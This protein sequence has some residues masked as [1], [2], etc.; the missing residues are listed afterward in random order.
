MI[1]FEKT[2]S[3]WSDDDIHFVFTDMNNAI[4]S[5]SGELITS[6]VTISFH[7]MRAAN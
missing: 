5:S 3:E 2:N 7:G 1:I 4:T 6:D